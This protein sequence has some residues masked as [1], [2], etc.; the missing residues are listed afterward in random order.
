MVL[1]TSDPSLSESDD[2]PP[3]DAEMLATVYTTLRPFTWPKNQVRT[4]QKRSTDRIII[5]VYADDVLS[6]VGQKKT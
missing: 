4:C 3:T 2:L 5:V 1:L 6:W